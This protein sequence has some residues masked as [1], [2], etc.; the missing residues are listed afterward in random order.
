MLMA[1]IRPRLE[2]QNGGSGKIFANPVIPQ[3]DD[4]YE[5]LPSIIGHL[6]TAPS[7]HQPTARRVH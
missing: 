6:H 3:I 4:Y 1:K 5:P 7:K 2:R